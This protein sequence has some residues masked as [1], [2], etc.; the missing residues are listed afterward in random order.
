MGD[1][2]FLSSNHL[3][4]AGSALAY[5]VLMSLDASS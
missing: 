5:I 2:E 1:R 4:A 3:A